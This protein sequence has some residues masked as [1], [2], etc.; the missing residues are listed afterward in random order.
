M[1]RREIKIKFQT[2]ELTLDS[3]ILT[4]VWTAHKDYVK[5]MEVLELL[6]Y[7]INGYR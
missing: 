1:R 7:Y 4:F 3:N 5:C 6:F 2:F